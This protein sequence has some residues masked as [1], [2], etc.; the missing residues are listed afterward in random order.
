MK[1]VSAEITLLLLAVLYE[2]G[3]QKV[4]AEPEIVF[5]TP[6]ASSRTFQKKKYKPAQG[7][8]ITC[9]TTKPSF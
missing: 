2:V 7:V 4:S 3:I 1:A 8:K 5:C 6:F 9:V